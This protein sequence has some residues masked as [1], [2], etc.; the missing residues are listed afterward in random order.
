MEGNLATCN[1]SWEEDVLAIAQN[2]MNSVEINSDGQNCFEHNKKGCFSKSEEFTPMKTASIEAADMVLM[3]NQNATKK[4]AVEV[5]ELLKTAVVQ[6]SDHRE[7]LSSLELC[8]KMAKSN[9]HED[10]LVL[11]NAIIG[12]YHNGKWKR[13]KALVLH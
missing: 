11:Y 9:T 5:L 7:G 1:L 2:E 6:S 13:G 3:S 10:W 12:Q 8:C 4:V